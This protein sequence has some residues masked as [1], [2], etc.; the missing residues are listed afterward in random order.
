MPTILAQSH[1]VCLP[2]YRE[3]LPKALLEAASCGRPI[4]TT[5]TNG[6]RELVR[7]GENGFLVPVKSTLELADALQLLIEDPELRKRMGARGREIAVNEFA[8]ERVV[9]ETMAVYEELLLG[10]HLSTTKSRCL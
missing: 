4:V 3:G 10:K 6:C 2:S 1:V 8:V 7:H 9:A 5:D